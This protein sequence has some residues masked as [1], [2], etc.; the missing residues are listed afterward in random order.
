MPNPFD[1]HFP[2]EDRLYRQAG[3]RILAGSRLGP[4]IRLR[5]S[6][7]SRGGSQRGVRAVLGDKDFDWP[8]LDRWRAEFT[9][10]G[11]FPDAADPLAWTPPE[12]PVERPY[13]TKERFLESLTVA[14]LREV[15]ADRGVPLQKSAQKAKLAAAL[16]AALTWEDVAA[17]AEAANEAHARKQRL[18]RIRAKQDLL[19]DSLTMCFHTLLRHA[20]I[21]DLISDG[22]YRYE[23]RLESPFGA[24]TWITAGLIAAWRFDPKNA[25]NLPPFFPGDHTRL[26]SGRQSKGR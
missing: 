17:R 12:A 24:D 19:C 5:L 21:A 23:P 25:A 13:A 6:L 14:G 8:W 15:A 9:K 10:R 3:E 16:A 26:T 2:D 22:L 4:E 18:S 7:A 20:E 1:L 11:R